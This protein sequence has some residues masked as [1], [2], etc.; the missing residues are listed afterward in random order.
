MKK[1]IEIHF[2]WV[3]N[4]GPTVMD[5]SSKQKLSNTAGGNEKVDYLLLKENWQ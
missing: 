5:D 2:H 1:N 4:N 3:S